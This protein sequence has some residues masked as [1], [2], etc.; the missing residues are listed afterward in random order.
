MSGFPNQPPLRRALGTRP[1]LGAQ[2]AEELA[3]DMLALSW[4]A[5]AHLGIDAV[6]VAPA[7]PLARQVAGFDEI[8]G[9]ALGGTFGDAHR[10][11]DVTHAYIWVVLDAQEHLRVIREEVPA[12]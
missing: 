2:Q 11:G 12:I 5:H 10:L 6:T 8:V 4:M 1:L 7:D 3:D 9:D